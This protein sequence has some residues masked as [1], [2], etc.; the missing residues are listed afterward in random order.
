MRSV[1]RFR[2]DQCPLAPMTSFSYYYFQPPFPALRQPINPTGARLVSEMTRGVVWKYISAVWKYI[3]V[4]ENTP[5]RCG[6][7]RKP[8]FPIFR[9]P[10]CRP[11][12]QKRSPHSMTCEH[13][14]WVA[15]FGFPI[16]RLLSLS[17]LNNQWPLK[18][19]DDLGWLP[20]KAM[21]CNVQC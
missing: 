5:L 16:T 21:Q 14:K 1:Q 18:I 6:F 9:F 8:H 15:C 2:G 12:P 17:L 19:K 20:P 3:F 10:F 4:L 13:T 11:P 7:A